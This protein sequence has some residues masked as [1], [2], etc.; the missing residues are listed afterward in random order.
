[1]DQTDQLTSNTRG[2][3]NENAAGFEEPSLFGGC[4][5][6]CCGKVNCCSVRDY[7]CRFCMEYCLAGCL[8][9]CCLASKSSN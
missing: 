2:T 8:T 6:N 3:Q 7:N 9:G 4:C 1:M 5:N